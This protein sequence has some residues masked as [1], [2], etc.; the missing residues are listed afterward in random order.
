[1]YPTGRKIRE[2]LKKHGYKAKTVSIKHLPEVQEAV[3]KLV[4][5]GLV[6]PRLSATWHFYL[7]SNKNPPE[8]GTIII[9]ALPQSITRLTFT[10]QGTIYP[11]EVTPGH[12][13]AADEARAEDILNRMLEEAGYR[14]VKARLALKTLAVR[15]G[16]AAYGKNN[17]AY[18]PEMGSFCRLVAFYS[19][20][21]CEEDNWQQY[22]LLER[23]D[24][25]TLCLNNC[26]TGSI[27]PGRFLIQ[28]EN[29][30][31]FLNENNPEFPYWVKL[32]PD[33]PNALIGCMS[34]QSI[35]PE[36]RPYLQNIIC[37]PSFS[38]E[39]T[40]CILQNM[41]WEKLS[42]ATKSKLEEIKW[43]YPLLVGNLDALIAKQKS[44]PIS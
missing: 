18:V 16:L 8:A 41:P 2:A 3:G 44:S 30:L 24:N 34:C 27:T 39:E 26:P 28:A 40:G 23:C 36:N 11:G 42:P 19:D 29:C 1:M 35:C 25:C 10:W 20:V 5:Q 15:S 43:A 31:G 6:N 7:Q 22:K 4:R 33:W 9:A 12:F 14:L 17:L 38:E 21:P 37:G 13:C 32:Q